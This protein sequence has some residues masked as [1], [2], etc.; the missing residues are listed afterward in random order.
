[1]C[2]D[3]ALTL[4]YSSLLFNFVSLFPRCLF[5][6]LLK[7]IGF[8]M[9]QVALKPLALFNSIEIFVHMPYEDMAI[10]LP[11]THLADG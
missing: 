6:R 11:F 5:I 1:M 7:Q 3:C 4:P 2:V 9:L 10:F 8:T